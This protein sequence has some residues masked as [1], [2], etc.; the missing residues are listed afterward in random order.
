MSQLRTLGLK[1]QTFSEA[2]Q[3]VTAWVMLMGAS[4]PHLSFFYTMLCPYPNADNYLSEGSHAIENDS[5]QVIIQIIVFNMQEDM[6]KSSSCCSPLSRRS[7]E[8]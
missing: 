6:I 8:Y 1:L 4:I 2:A 7:K 3:R 5:M